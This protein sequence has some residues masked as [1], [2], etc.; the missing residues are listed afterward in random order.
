MTGVQTCALP[1][2]FISAKDAIIIDTKG[3]E[4]LL[5][6][7]VSREM[8]DHTILE[9]ILDDYRKSKKG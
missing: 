4:F 9:R 2:F 3:L 8:I 5:D 6:F 7:L 1:I